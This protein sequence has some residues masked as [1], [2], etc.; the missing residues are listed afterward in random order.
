MLAEHSAR[1]SDIARTHHRVETVVIGRRV[2]Q[3]FVVVDRHFEQRRECRQVLLPRSLEPRVVGKCV[4][5]GMKVEV[6]DQAARSRPSRPV[7]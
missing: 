2:L 5:L 6:Y 7:N 1:R 3:I 4:D